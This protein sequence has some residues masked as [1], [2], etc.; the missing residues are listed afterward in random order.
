MSYF[1]VGLELT[2]LPKKFK[3]WPEWLIEEEAKEAAKEFAKI[4]DKD[5]SII[6]LADNLGIEPAT[7]FIPKSDWLRH[8]WAARPIPQPHSS[9]CVEVN[10]YPMR[11]T[12]FP[13]FPVSDGLVRLYSIA[14]SIG[15][16][17]YVEKWS[18]NKKIK[19]EYP[20][21]GGHLH[22]SLDFWDEGASYLINLWYLERAI[23]LDYA[24]YPFIKWLFSQWFDDQN[25]QLAVPLKL[26]KEIEETKKNDKTIDHKDIVYVIHDKT[27]NCHSIKQRTA[28]TGKKVYPTW[29]F[30]FF[31]M[32]RTA[33]ELQ[34]QVKF[35]EAWLD[36][37]IKGINELNNEKKTNGLDQVK[38]T[39]NSKYFT[40][41]AKDPSFAE[42]EI[43]QFFSM[44]GLSFIKDGF[45]DAFFDRN[46]VTRM[47]FGQMF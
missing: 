6:N 17:P 23:C 18:K 37:R 22:V 1:S 4:L 42:C 30:R 28:D 24:N 20:T 35:L 34:L 13:W 10:N 39:L 11:V 2:W 12:S 21:G 43:F 31:D 45:K 9:W 15:L 47:K 3:K 44:I 38:Y 27:L 36:Y 41:L 19:T 29:E 14:N 16:T 40:K 32:P 26:T 46:Y 25:S 5:E 33:K 8:P 7:V